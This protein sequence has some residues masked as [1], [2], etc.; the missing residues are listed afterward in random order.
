[1]TRIERGKVHLQ[2]QPVELNDLAQ[3]GA[4]DHGALFAA[5]EVH[6][7]LSPAPEEVWVDGDRTRLAQ[8]IGNLLQNAAKFTTPGGTTTLEVI[9]DRAAR[10]AILSVR[11]TS[12]GISPPLLPHLFEPFAQADTSLVRQKGGLGLGLALVKGLVEMHGGSV[13]GESDGEGRGATFTV[14]LPLEA[15]PDVGCAP[16]RRPGGVC[17]RVLVIEDNVD[18][19]DTLREALSMSGHVVEAAYAGPEGIE[20]ARAFGPDVVLCDIGLPGM[21]GFEVARAMRA[22]PVL[23]RASIIA[24]TGYALPEDIAKAR[25]AGFDGHL[26]KPPSLEELT[27]LLARA[28]ALRT[29][30]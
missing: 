11:D 15:A 9:A 20:K 3:R 5:S 4:E 6:L 29:G 17:R 23:G 7:E 22:D 25:E 12:S 16:S 13:S 10:Q 1:M 2:R 14:R 8:V 21:D 30:E 18:T 28:P 27:A 19:A 26:A 24:L